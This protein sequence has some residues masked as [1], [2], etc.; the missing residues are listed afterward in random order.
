MICEICKKE[1]QSTSG[2]TNH[3]LRTHKITPKDYYDTYIE[4]N[5]SHKCMYCNKPTKFLNLTKGYRLF[6]SRTCCNM[7]DYHIS[8]MVQTTTERYGGMGTASK[9]INTK[10]KNTN[11]KKYGTENVYASNYGKQKIEESNLKKYG[12]KYAFQAAEVKEKIV[13]TAL[14]KYNTSNPANCRSGR[15]KAAITRRNNDND[16][17]W[18]DYFENQLITLDIS[19]KKRYKDSR[20]P[21]YCD[22]YLEDSDTFIEINGYWSH[23][24]HWFDKNSKEDQAKLRLW[25]Q[26]SKA[27]HKQY[28]NAIN[29]WTTSDIEKRDTAIKN[30]LNYIVLWKFNDMIDFFTKY[31]KG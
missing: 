11:L 14:A 13:Q 21:Y 15:Q 27:G 3:I 16:S 8:K 24:G 18:E 31:K 2:F 4:P 12:V 6:C 20:Y 26:K 29:V 30:H 7:S 9:S 25:T 1:I 10:I 22:F 19:Y 5:K 28:T 17:S 23:G